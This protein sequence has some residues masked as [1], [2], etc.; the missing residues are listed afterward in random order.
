VVAIVEA[1]GYK[2]DLD[3]LDSRVKDIL[4][5]GAAPSARIPVSL[6]RGSILS[7]RI[8]TIGF[9]G[10]Y[11][12]PF[13]GVMEMQARFLAETWAKHEPTAQK[14]L[15]NRDVYKHDTTTRM[16]KAI[17]ER[18]SQIPQFWMADYVGLMEEFAREAGT[19]RDDSAFG[20]QQSGPAF[21]SRYQ[22]KDTGPQAK[23]VVSEVAEVMRASNEDARF[24]AAAVF[25]GMQ[26]IWNIHRTIESK[27][28]TPGG[29]FKGTAHFHPRELTSPAFDKEYLYI[30]SGTFTMNTGLAFPATRRYVY[31][32]NETK[33]QITS[34]FV[35]EDNESV[36]SLFNTWEFF[37]PNEGERKGWKAKG[38]HWCAP[39]T[40][41]NTCEF[42]FKGAKVERFMIRY[43]AE[44]P[45]KDYQHESWYE[46]P[47]AEGKEGV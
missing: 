5:E 46:R 21:P 14:Q 10:F 28:D 8:P 32:Y 18:S 44:G 23:Q 25:T 3:W 26:G 20:G 15:P 30:E 47:K 43:T 1:T 7:P 38:H 2:S 4:N 34:W 24:V 42:R 39:D 19:T 29:T 35:Q 12:G 36:G 45:K 17:N 41:R 31:R 16:Q 22:S 40:Y 6:S 33:D 11:E 27:T 9:V 13:W 37:P